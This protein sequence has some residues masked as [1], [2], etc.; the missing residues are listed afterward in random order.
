MEAK[1]LAERLSELSSHNEV[2]DAVCAMIMACLAKDPAHRPPSAAAVEEWISSSDEPALPPVTPMAP[3][4]TVT[5]S[6]LGDAP[7]TK[8]PPPMPTRM[9]AAPPMLESG[10]PTVHERIAAAG[11]GAIEA[12]DNPLH[13]GFYYFTCILVVFVLVGGRANPSSLVSSLIF[14]LLFSL[15]GRFI[16]KPK[17]YACSQCSGKL[18]S[19]RPGPCPHCDASLT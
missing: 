4:P 9:D 17:R 16:I 13:Q 14:V 10:Q 19:D 1:H 12:R 3:L 18:R 15:I 5:P 7:S 11:W 2:P 8:P 6:T